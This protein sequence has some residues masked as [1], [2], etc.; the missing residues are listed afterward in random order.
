MRPGRKGLKSQTFAH[1]EGLGFSYK[2]LRDF[3]MGTV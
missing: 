3:N 1:D 2:S